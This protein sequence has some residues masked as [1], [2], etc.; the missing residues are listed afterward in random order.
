MAPNR[1]LATNKRRNRRRTPLRSVKVVCQRGSLGLG[2]DIAIGLLDLS[3]EGACLL[4]KDELKRGQEVTL[5][6]DSIRHRRPLEVTGTVS[7]SR[8]RSEGTWSIG[9]LLD[10]F[11]PYAEVNL[12]TQV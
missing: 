7:W 4:V 1:P 2:P 12:F 3:E 8:L 11:L 5:T 6:L 10:K 9:V